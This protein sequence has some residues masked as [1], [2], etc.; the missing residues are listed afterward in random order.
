MATASASG[1]IRTFDIILV[2]LLDIVL[3][4]LLLG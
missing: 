1:D 4:G 2:G 3:V